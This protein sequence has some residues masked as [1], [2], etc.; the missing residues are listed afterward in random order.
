MIRGP[1][2]KNDRSKKGC[3]V[4]IKNCTKGLFV[5]CADRIDERFSS[6]DFLPQ[7][8]VNENVCI[9]CN[10]NCEDDSGYPWEGEGGSKH[11]HCSEKD[12]HIDREPDES[13]KTCEA[14]IDDDEKKGESESGDCCRHTLAHYFLTIASSDIALGKDVEGVF[15]GVVE[16]I[17]NRANFLTSV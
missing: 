3:D 10:T 7:A 9:N 11:R 16:S 1:P 8:F 17:R 13:D 2:K 5:G 4:R 15:Q 12:E 6:G 14:I